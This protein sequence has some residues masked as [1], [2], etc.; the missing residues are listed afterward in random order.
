[1]DDATKKML[2]SIAAPIIR[3]GLISAGSALTAHGLMSSNYTEAFVS[4]GLALA[5]AAWSF[6]N[7]YGRAIVLSQLEVLKAK[8]LAQATKL[9][10]HNIAGPDA[11]AV[12]AASAKSPDMATLSIE[13]V[14]K[15][16]ATL[17]AAVAGATA[18]LALF[19]VALTVAGPALAQGRPDDLP[20]APAARPGFKPI[21]P[22][23]R[24]VEKATESDDD[25]SAEDLLTKLDAAALSD[26]QYALK[27][28]KA[29]DSK[30][31]I[32]CLEAAVA[33]IEAR[34][35][36]LKDTDVPPD[37]ALI[38]KAVRIMIAYEAF[39]PESPLMIACAPLNNKVK[40]STRQIIGQIFTG[41]AGLA[42]V[43]AG[44]FF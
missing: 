28:A 42:K 7:D 21:G 8:S 24:T 6:W 44:G 38:T 26:A 20:R 23:G 11:Q 39:Q 32:A 43:F 17:P 35:A 31:I 1:M 9:Q 37:P 5:G 4:L 33:R 22:I 27:I 30:L 15:T 41:G 3:K 19:F 40:M 12:A 10:Q 18:L 29:A 14:K 25:P 34:Q 16:A 13:E 2:V 36:A